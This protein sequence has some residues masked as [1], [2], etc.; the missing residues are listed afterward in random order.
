MPCRAIRGRVLAPGC[1]VYINDMT[2]H[3]HT[4]W[5]EK[6]F[7]RSELFSWHRLFMFHMFLF[8]EKSCFDSQVLCRASGAASDDVGRPT[9][10]M[11]IS[12][13]A[14]A[15]PHVHE[16]ADTGARA[17]RHRRTCTRTHIQPYR[18]CN[19]IKIV[20]NKTTFCIFILTQNTHT[21]PHSQNMT[22]VIRL[23][24]AR[25]RAYS[26]SCTCKWRWAAN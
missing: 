17:R 9:V 4:R 19:S 12:A 23:Y 22:S 10:T 2:Q 18:A 1:H 26:Y 3:M 16:H 14:H 25:T 6:T 8:Q 21:T 13:R 24:R 15:L 5:D 7:G 11:P 20:D